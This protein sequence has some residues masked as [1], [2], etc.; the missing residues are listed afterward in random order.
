MIARLR[1]A[2]ANAGDFLKTLALCVVI[3]IALA[4]GAIDGDDAH[5][6]DTHWD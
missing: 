5:T 1:R 6:D 4:F 2:G 3:A